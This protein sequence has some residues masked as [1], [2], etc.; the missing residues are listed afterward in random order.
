MPTQNFQAKPTLD[1]SGNVSW[2]LCH[3][4]PNPDD[5]GDS[6]ATY[7]DITLGKGTGKHTIK[8]TITDDQ[9]GL[10][11][12]FSDEPLWIKKGGQPTG[13]G[14]DPQIEP[15][16]GNGT[17]VLTFVDKNSKPDKA[18]PGPYVLTYQLNFVDKDNKKVT[19]IDPDIRNGGTT[20]SF[21]QTTM[22]IAGAGLV[23]LLAAVLLSIR[24]MRRRREV[25]AGGRR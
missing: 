12:K 16:T 14:G 1:K 17:Q 8:F 23:L 21:D 6:K 15:P 18:D 5:C 11:I 22:L 25:N 9:T 19:S 2:E 24:S 7:P 4:N 3:T 10:G 20:K 13:P